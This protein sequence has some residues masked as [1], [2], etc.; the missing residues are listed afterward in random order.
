[1]QPSK[2]T[3]TQEMAHALD[4]MENTNEHIFLTGRAGTGKST[5]LRLFRDQTRK[6]IAILAPTGIAA[7][8][9]RGQTIHSFFNFPPHP[10]HKGIIGK[11]KDKKV[12]E[13][14]DTIVID[15]ISMVRADLLD[16]IDYFL[17]L[18]GKHRHLPFGGIQ[19]IFIGDLLQLPPIIAAEMERKLFAFLY[20]T[21]FFFSANALYHYPIHFVELTT[22]FRQNDAIFLHLL[23][24]VRTRNLDKTALELLNSRVAPRFSPPDDVYYITLCTTNAIADSINRDKLKAL[25][26]PIVVFTATQ[27]GK[28]EQNALPTDFHLQL[29]EGAQ[30]MFLKNDLYGRW[31]NGT[32]GKV[33][34]LDDETVSV[35]ISSE[36]G[37]V[38]HIV[39]K[40]TW[41]IVEYVYSEEE[42][43]IET[44]IIGS[45]TQYPLK[46]AWAVTIHKSQGQ[47]FERAIIDIGR[48]AFAPGQIYVA[49]SRCTSLEGI[50]LRQK[51]RE[52]DIII[53]EKILNFLKA[54][55]IG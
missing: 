27:E 22:V 1:M 30:V 39:E 28:F 36:K 6:K 19:M 47:T 20:E 46:L 50:V 53:D 16:G 14:L 2:L 45:F 11:R 12:F 17:R 44:K 9:V 26:A 55:G 42:R 51:I 34:F 49:L 48:G 10:L 40:S 13:N 15:E 32:L 7:I 5:L 8:Q 52:S 21:P 54:K 25:P 37:E 33:N 38:V 29:K 18:N 31:V 3:L 4:L 41:E 24:Q 43:K 35:L 23:N